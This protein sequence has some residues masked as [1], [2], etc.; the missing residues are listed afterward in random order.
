MR[1]KNGEKSRQSGFLRR[2]RRNRASDA[3]WQEKIDRHRGCDYTDSIPS[4][5]VSGE[6][7]CEGMKRAEEPG[8]GTFDGQIR[9]VYRHDYRQFRRRMD[10]RAVWLH[11]DGDVE[12]CRRGSG[13]LLRSKTIERLKTACESQLNHGNNERKE[14]FWQDPIT[15]SKSGN[16][17]LQRRR[18]KKRSA[19]ASLTA[20]LK[21][22]R[23]KLPPRRRMRNRKNLQ[24]PR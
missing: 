6:C 12:R 9:W 5:V 17:N 24:P 4:P 21:R 2:R 15:N 20:S 1:S 14:P 8:T 18:R 3:G 11:V 22:L 19:S 7:A 10:R 13:V 16:E 23:M